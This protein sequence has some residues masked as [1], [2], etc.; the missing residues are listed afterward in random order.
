MSG[1]RKK[2]IV[3]LSI[4]QNQSNISVLKSLFS[5]FLEKGILQKGRVPENCCANFRWEEVFYKKFLPTC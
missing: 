1:K 2:I 5:K 3:H 4:I